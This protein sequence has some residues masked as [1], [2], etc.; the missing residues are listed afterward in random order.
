MDS[1]HW[2]LIQTFNQ[3]QVKRW[4]LKHV[5]M[6]KYCV[7]QQRTEKAASAANQ[8]EFS[9]LLVEW[10]ASSVSPFMISE[11]GGLQKVCD[12]AGSVYGHLKLPSQNKVKKNIDE[13]AINQAG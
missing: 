3:K 1:R 12:F 6:E 10:I 7:K 4:Q 13:L 11:D 9:N 2:D 5:D 8:K